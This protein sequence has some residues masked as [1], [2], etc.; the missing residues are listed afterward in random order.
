LKLIELMNLFSFRNCCYFDAGQIIGY[1]RYINSD[2]INPK[3]HVYEQRHRPFFI[4]N[5][6]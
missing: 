3:S 4:E 6:H 2:I 1:P 5:W